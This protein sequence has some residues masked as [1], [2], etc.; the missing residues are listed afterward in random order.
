MDEIVFRWTD[1]NDP[2]FQHFYT[3]T[4]AYYSR[5]AGGKEKRSGFISFNASGLIPDVILAYCN[6]AAVGCAGIKRYSDTDAEVKRLWVEPD[7]RGRHI[8]ASLMDQIEEKARQMGY[9]RVILQTRPIMR[10][11]VKL[12]EKRCY[13]LI[14]NYPPYDRLAGAICYAKKL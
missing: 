3:V 7:F 13:A 14:P 9:R 5:I 6:G 2:A 10:D 4:E 11:A 1:G 12:Y 8:A